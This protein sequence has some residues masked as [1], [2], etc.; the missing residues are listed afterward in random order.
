MNTDLPGDELGE[1]S[2]ARGENSQR[3][4]HQSQADDVEDDGEYY[5]SPRSVSERTRTSRA[6]KRTHHRPR[7]QDGARSCVQ[8]GSP[9]IGHL[10]ISHGWHM[11]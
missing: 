11:L 10:C 2:G 4:G 7:M 5:G 8:S 6:Q 3:D 1:A 9:G